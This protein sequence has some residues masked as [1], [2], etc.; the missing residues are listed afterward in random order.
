MTMPGNPNPLYLATQAQSMARNAEASDA[1]IF[2]KVALCSMCV[3][4]VASLVQVF[5]P[6]LKE[7]NR[8]HDKDNSRSR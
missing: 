7:L 6:L 8:R 1:R 4:A 5:Q 3:M 2:Q